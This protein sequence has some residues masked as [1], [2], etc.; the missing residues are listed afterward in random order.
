[1]RT[2]NRM[3]LVAFAENVVLGRRRR[4]HHR[5]IYVRVTTEQ[6]QLTL[7]EPTQATF[8]I[9]ARNHSFYCLPSRF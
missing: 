6:L 7:S 5:S 9:L 1:M 8:S 4:R 3:N 2:T